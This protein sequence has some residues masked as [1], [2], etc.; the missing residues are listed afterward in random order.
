MQAF[1]GCIFD[2]GNDFAFI[3]CSSTS[4]L[5]QNLLKKHLVDATLQKVSLIVWRIGGNCVVTL[6]YACIF[7]QVS[8]HHEGSR[9]KCRA[10][11]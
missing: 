7:N 6:A 4:K 8:C 9:I 10:G 2:T 5:S 3:S 1:F 11:K